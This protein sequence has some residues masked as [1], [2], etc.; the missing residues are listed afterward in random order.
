MRANIS[1]SARRAPSQ[2]RTARGAGADQQPTSDDGADFV[3]HLI[4][5]SHGAT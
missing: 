4:A 5:H 2:A 3:A 1:H